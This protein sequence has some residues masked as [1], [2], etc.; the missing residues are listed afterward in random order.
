[1]PLRPTPPNGRSSYG[2]GCAKP[3]GSLVAIHLAEMVIKRLQEMHHAQSD[4]VACDRSDMHVF[5]VVGA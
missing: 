1:M 5:D 4:A 3:V 2:A